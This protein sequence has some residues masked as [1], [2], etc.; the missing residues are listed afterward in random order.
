[1]QTLYLRRKAATVGLF[2]LSTILLLASCNQSKDA[3]PAKFGKALSASK[4]R[5]ALEK[6]TGKKIIINI[7]PV[8]LSDSANKN[9]FDQVFILQDA[10]VNGKNLGDSIDEAIFT[11]QATW[12]FND[13]KRRGFTKGS[14][15]AGYFIQVDSG[16]ARTI[17]SLFAECSIGE[18]TVKADYCTTAE[19][20]DA[21]VVDSPNP[22]KPPAPN[23]CD[24]PLFNWRDSTGKCPPCLLA[25][26]LLLQGVIEKI[27]VQVFSNK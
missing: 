6:S 4:I 26:S 3:T 12:Y 24:N 11:Q 18:T 20:T 14:V 27:Q 5:A 9:D 8:K 7:Y 25:E 22:Q 21:P 15:S 1:M 10:V 2:V 16:F 17:K 13:L 19:D 23:S